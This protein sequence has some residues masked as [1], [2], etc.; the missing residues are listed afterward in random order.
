MFVFQPVPTPEGSTAPPTTKQAKVSIL[1]RINMSAVKGIKL[2]PPAALQRLTKLEQAV[3][4][5]VAKL[6][7]YV[8]NTWRDPTLLRANI[9]DIRDIAGKAKVVLRLLTEFGLSTLVNSQKLGQQELTGMISRAIEPLLETYYSLKITLQRLDDTDWK[10]PL[11]ERKDKEHDD[12]DMI[13]AYMTGVPQD[14]KKL[15]TVIRTAATALYKLPKEPLAPP[16]E[17][18]GEQTTPIAQP[19]PTVDRTT[20]TDNANSDEKKVT[21]RI[22]RFKPV[23]MEAESAEV[24]STSMMVGLI[25][26]CVDAN[27]KPGEGPKFSP[28]TVRRLCGLSSNSS[29]SLKD[30]QRNGTSNG[31]VSPKLPP[32]RSDSITNDSAPRPPTRQDSSERVHHVRQKS[33]ERFAP[34]GE[35]APPKTKVPPNPPPKPKLDRK[36][37]I[38]KSY[39]YRGKED[40]EESSERPV[41]YR[42]RLP[43]IDS[44]KE[45]RKCN[46]DPTDI[47]RIAEDGN[48]NNKDKRVSDSI[49]TTV[50]GNT[51]V[52]RSFASSPSHSSD[53]ALPISPTGQRS[54]TPLS[55]RLK[56]FQGN[57]KPDI[58]IQRSK[59]F[60]RTKPPAAKTPFGENGMNNFI[61]SFSDQE[62]LEFYKY[63]IDA[64][65]FVLN[66]AMK[67]L[68]AS[69]DEN[70]PPKVFVSNSKFI[71][72]SAHKF[73]YIGE[74]LKNKISHDKL[75]SEITVV[76]TKLSDCAKKLVHCTKLAALQYSAVSP[77]REMAT[78]ASAVSEAAIELHR[79][80]KLKTNS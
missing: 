1:Q 50:P 34:D 36:P 9:A 56:E 11:G 73:I 8:T 59:S 26:A 74:T 23:A 44:P 40:S 76:T 2:D 80:V 24:N 39:K 70:R 52:S 28:E 33:I 17:E 77:M 48:N 21:S 79:V 42:A 7:S 41:K 31:V 67:S 55:P 78:A 37:T 22:E 45:K 61:L 6:L 13:M 4:V 29:S 46:S 5:T 63:E 16:P 20:K 58:K 10:G 15:A 66:E 30:M 54:V 14:S 60:T 27:I 18:K 57:P 53:S 49:E 75:G 64:Q 35:A 65:L 69:I 25:K 19:Q 43:G 32:R 47:E 38:R 68:F 3:D 51:I 71:V 62:L 72:L 12:L